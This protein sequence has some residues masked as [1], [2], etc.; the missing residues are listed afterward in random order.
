MRTQAAASAILTVAVAAG[1]VGFD[2]LI[3]VLIGAAV[4]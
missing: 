3:D 4:A 2:P 1:E